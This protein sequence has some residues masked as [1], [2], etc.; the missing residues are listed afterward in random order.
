MIAQEIIARQVP[1]QLKL[2]AAPPLQTNNNWLYAGTS[3]AW[4]NTDYTKPPYNICTEAE[5]IA[6]AP[7]TVHR[8]SGMLQLVN[9]N[10]QTRRY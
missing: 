1:P 7:A 4:L 8:G 3:E 10:R 6:Y 2:V 5:T 9:S